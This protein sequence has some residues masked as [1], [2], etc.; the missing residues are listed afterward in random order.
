MTRGPLCNVPGC[1]EPA[2]AAVIQAFATDS[3]V[4]LCDDHF[5]PLRRVLLDEYARRRA[6]V[7]PASHAID[8]DRVVLSAR[9]G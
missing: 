6:P 9:D 1:V 5:R 7:E 2:A 4:Y 8:A 3:R